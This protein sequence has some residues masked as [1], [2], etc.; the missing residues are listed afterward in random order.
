MKIINTSGKRKRSIAR[1]TLKEGRGIIKINN[2]PLDVIG[3]MLS[4]LKIQE[5]L[6]LA[7]DV[8]KKVNITVNIKGGGFMSQADAARVA[9]CRAL[10]EFAPH[11][12]KV[13]LDYLSN[14]YR[15]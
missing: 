3:P 8:T 4:R 13:Y 12:K 11:L 1:A 15:V 2:K 10:V 14:F 9:I 6:L 5:A 7:G